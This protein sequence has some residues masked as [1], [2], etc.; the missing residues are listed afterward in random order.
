MPVQRPADSCTLHPPRPCPCRCH[1]RR[2][3]LP[4]TPPQGYNA[5]IVAYGQ[6]GTGKTY[7]ME[8]E[9]APSALGG[10]SHSAGII[11]RAIEDVF[12]YIQRDTGERCKFLVRASYLQARRGTQCRGLLRGLRWGRRSRRA[13]QGV[14]VEWGFR[15]RPG[16]QGPRA[17]GRCGS[18]VQA[19]GWGA[20]G[21]QPSLPLQ[22]C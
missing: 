13:G 4:P 16:Q 12:A 18:A 2:R 19:L 6:T 20:S 8:G 14:P 10:A 15:L 3:C 17:A 5:S 9:R 7:T 21:N 22:G 11:P 1:P